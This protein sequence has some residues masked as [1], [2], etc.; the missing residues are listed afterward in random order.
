MKKTAVMGI[1]MEEPLKKQVEA[2]AKKERRSLADQAAYLI[3]AGLNVHH[4]QNL[5]RAIKHLKTQSPP[6]IS[7]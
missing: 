6:G 1:R 3:E 7:G 2:M 4:V 5:H